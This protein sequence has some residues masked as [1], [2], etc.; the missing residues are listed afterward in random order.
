MRSWDTVSAAAL[1][2]RTTGAVAVHVLTVARDGFAIIALL[3]D[4]LLLYSTHNIT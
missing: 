1:V 4:A 3:L 2:K